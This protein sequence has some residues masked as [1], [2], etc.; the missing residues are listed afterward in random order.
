MVRIVLYLN[1]A[2]TLANAAQ[3]KVIC[4]LEISHLYPNMSY[5]NIL[6][7]FA[8]LTVL[9]LKTNRMSSFLFITS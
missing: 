2:H 5:L 1:E 9:T 8:F 7:K 6:L 3:S 4:V